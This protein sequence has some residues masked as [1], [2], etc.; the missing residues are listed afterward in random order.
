[1]NVSLYWDIFKDYILTGK[2]PNVPETYIMTSHINTYC[3]VMLKLIQCPQ[4]NMKKLSQELNMKESTVDNIVRDAV[5]IG[6]IKR[7]NN[8]LILL[9]E[10]EEE[11]IQT[12]K[13]YCLDHIIYNKI[14]SILQ[15]KTIISADDFINIIKPIY[16]ATFE[17]KT[18]KMY[19]NK[20]LAWFC[21]LNLLSLNYKYE[22]ALSSERLSSTLA[23]LSKSLKQI[24]NSS[25]TFLGGAPHERV[26][27]LINILSN[28]NISIQNISTK[29]RNAISILKRIGLLKIINDNLHLTTLDKERALLTL[30]ENVK[31]SPQL[32]YI[33]Q[34]MVQ[35]PNLDGKAI[36]QMLNQK[37][38]YN[39]KNTSEI[40]T[41]NALKRWWKWAF[42]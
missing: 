28:D 6:N 21:N 39:W 30:K 26:C 40:R 41:G 36:G 15:Q 42:Q 14:K 11:I 35:N 31:K 25:N 3:K 16:K 4:T 33:N 34:L 13:N 18:W 10:N 9:Q 29:Y 5:M 12:M 22:I 2:V 38:N 37:F 32:S 24:Q 20:M 17:E 27:E 7:T 19:A 23:D 1:M 8:D